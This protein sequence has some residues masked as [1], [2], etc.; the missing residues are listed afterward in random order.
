V[1]GDFGRYSAGALRRE[2]ALESLPRWRKSRCR[3]DITY[4]SYGRRV[5]EQRCG[6]LLQVEIDADNDLRFDWLAAE[7]RGTIPPLT[8]RR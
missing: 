3:H 8:D 6:G 1:Q 4:T 2:S 5:K 7:R